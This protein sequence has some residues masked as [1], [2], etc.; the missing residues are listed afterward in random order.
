MAFSLRVPSASAR[1]PDVPKGVRP[2]LV[3]VPRGA[4]RVTGRALERGRDE[5]RP[6]PRPPPPTE[7]AQTLRPGGRVIFEEWRILKREMS[8]GPG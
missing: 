3:R 5:A 1:V 8:G 4:G 2:P 7:T 6:A